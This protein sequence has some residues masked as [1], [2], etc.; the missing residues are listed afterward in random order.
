MFGPIDRQILSMDY[1]KS[2]TANPLGVQAPMTANPSALRASTNKLKSTP[3]KI[4]MD[5]SGCSF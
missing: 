1:A 4:A 2:P 3:F 5:R